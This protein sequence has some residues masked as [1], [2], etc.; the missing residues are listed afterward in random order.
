MPW[1]SLGWQGKIIF[2]KFLRLF[3][4]L[5]GSNF[6]KHGKIVEKNGI[7]PLHLKKECNSWKFS[8]KNTFL[9]FWV[10]GW[11]ENGFGIRVTWEWIGW[12]EHGLALQWNISKSYKISMSS[13]KK[14]L[15]YRTFIYKTL[16]RE[17]VKSKVWL[18]QH[19]SKYPGG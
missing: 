13:L 14:C 8:Y 17:V 16:K 3:W 9:K 15:L 19:N 6:V 18:Y 4:G 2:K 10:L 1:F 12:P 11:P 5:Y 7:F